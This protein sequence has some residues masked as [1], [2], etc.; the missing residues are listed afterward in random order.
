MPPSSEP[1][2]PGAPA[3]I[4]LVCEANICRSPHLAELLRERL[5]LR[6]GMLVL[7]AGTHAR[8]GAPACPTMSAALDL[9]ESAIAEHRATQF[10][11]ELAARS[12]LILA[13][14]V[15]ERRRA[16][17]IAPEAR[18]KTF[19]VIE[20]VRL[21]RALEHGSPRTCSDLRGFVADLQ[22]QRK[23]SA[24]NDDRWHVHRARERTDS[25]RDPHRTRARHTKVAEQLERLADDLA[26]F[27]P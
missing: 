13:A 18:A 9:S 19:T 7:D 6:H 17:E 4:T 5:H 3:T 2:Q 27:L 23:R 24:A 20:A 11:A 25:V 15:P 1:S 21:A 8:V 26:Q 10:T 14:G 22:S 16:A 12:D